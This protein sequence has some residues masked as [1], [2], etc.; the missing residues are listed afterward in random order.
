MPNAYRVL[1]T[2]RPWPDS[3]VERQI[4]AEIGAEVVEAPDAQ[5]PTLVELA[6]EADAIATCWGQVTE[7]VVRAAPRCRIIS[8]L[9]IGLDNIAVETATELGIPV[10]NVPDYCIEEVAEH[11]LA[12]L[13]ACARK[14]AFFHHR[15]KQGEYDLQAGGSMRRVARRTLGLVGLGRIGSAVAQRAR[16]FGLQVLAYNRSGD[17]HGTGCTMVP[18]A[19]LLQRSDFVSL[20]VPLTDDTQHLID[21][22]SLALMQPAACLIN[23]SR[24]GL[25]DHDALWGALRQD[26]LAAVALDVYDPEPP[27]LSQPLYRDERVVM[28]P[29]A[30]FLSEE[31]LANL[32]TRAATQILQALQGVQPENVVNPQVYSSPRRRSP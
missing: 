28:T 7:A 1:I 26:R 22:E 17:D 24:G 27:D 16:A 21:A 18:L 6:V 30:A 23:T 15:L 13:L 12:L 32:R 9:G 2:D 5:E 25:I 20:H 4:L 31:S 3:E 29:H 14:V 11:T 8:R 19:E 10:T